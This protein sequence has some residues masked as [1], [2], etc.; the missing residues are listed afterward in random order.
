MRA[1]IIDRQALRDT[2][3][4]LGIDTVAELSAKTGVSVWVL[5]KALDTGRMQP[6]HVKRI[7]ETLGVERER[8]VVNGLEV[9]R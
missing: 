4:S 8:F 9:A 7:T 5:Y 1:L 2:M 6:S 3:A